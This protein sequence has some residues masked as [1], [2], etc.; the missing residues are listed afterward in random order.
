LDQAT[1]LWIAMTADAE[2]QQAAAFTAH[3]QVRVV[4][5]YNLAAALQLSNAMTAVCFEFDHIDSDGLKLVSDTKVRFPSTPV[6]MLTQQHSAE[7]VLWAL[8]TRVF[9]V[10]LK[11]AA[12]DEIRRCVERLQTIMSVRR[13]QSARKVAASQV[14]L[15]REARHRMGVLKT[16][17]QAVAAHIA[18]NYTQQINETELARQCEMSPF[19]FSREFR[20]AFGV[21]FRDHLCNLRLKE[22]ARLLGNPGIPI[23]H[24]AALAGFNDPSYFAR[25]FRKRAGCVPSEYRKR[26]LA[27]SGSRARA[28][29]DHTPLISRPA[30]VSDATSE[31][32][33]SAEP[34]EWSLRSSNNVS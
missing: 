3:C 12:N 9:D 15:P 29:T 33:T 26:L 6:L 31:D 21:T 18:K 14:L 25:A 28:A 23:T 24:V 32:T 13:Q 7:I 2:R 11:P 17:L 5:V 8:R 4:D 19:Q 20:K 34:T 16:R 22:A 27:R 10:L 1:L 30:A